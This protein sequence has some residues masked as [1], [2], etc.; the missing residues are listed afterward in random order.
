MPSFIKG[1]LCHTVS[2]QQYNG[3]KDTGFMLHMLWTK[4]WKNWIGGFYFKKF[5]ICYETHTLIVK[6]VSIMHIEIWQ[7]ITKIQYKTVTFIQWDPCQREKKKKTEQWRTEEDT[8]CQ[9]LAHK[10]TLTYAYL[11]IRMDGRMDTHTHWSW[12]AKKI[13]QLVKCLPTCTRPQLGP[14]QHIQPGWWCTNVSQ[15]SGKEVKPGDQKPISQSLRSA[16]F[17]W[18]PAFK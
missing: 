12:K 6:W 18:D 2:S 7:H 1:G 5:L 9:S 4:V 14:Q 15:Y 16:W 13:A 3:D 17:R 11:C 10:H 8:Q